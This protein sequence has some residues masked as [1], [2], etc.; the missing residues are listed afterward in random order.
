MEFKTPTEDLKGFVE[1][2]QDFWKYIDVDQLKP[3][4]HDSEDVSEEVMKKRLEALE[5][6]EMNMELY[7][8]QKS[9]HEQNKMLE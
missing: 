1:R 7:L 5:R 3:I 4:L 2:A 9:D 6:A 8:K